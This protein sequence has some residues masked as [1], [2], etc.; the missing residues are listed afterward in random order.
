MTVW[1]V[2]AGKHGE[3]ETLAL[4]HN[5]AVIGWEDLPDLSSISSREGLIALL[6]ATYPDEKPKTIINWAGQIWPFLAGM[7]TGDLVAVPIK[8]RPVIAIGE[9]TGPYRHRP[10][11]PPDARH[12]RQVRWLKEIPRDRFDQDLLY[13]LGAFMTVCRIQRNN[14]EERIRALLANSTRPPTIRP[15]GET[16]GDESEIEGPPDLEQLAKDQIVA[17]IGR[18]FKGHDLARL[19][20]AL[21]EAQGYTVRVSPPGGDGG[22]DIIAGKGHLGFD[23][24]KLVVQVKSGSNAVDVKVVR[25]LQGV[26]GN[27]KADYGLLVSW[28][29]YTSAAIRETATKFF[30]IRLWDSE[31]LV[32]M[33]QMYYPDLPAAVQAE[34]P[35]KRIWMLVPEEVE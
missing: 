31:D 2:R 6:E 21:L 30:E 4:E 25:E 1:L 3:R 7:Q 17:L 33:I 18:T 11:F 34:L 35:L 16:R 26:M 8:S 23:S 29:G 20:G 22:V 28:G 27:F 9:V 10:E 24:P 14:A 5:V 15:A 12:T 19:V 32:T 13:S